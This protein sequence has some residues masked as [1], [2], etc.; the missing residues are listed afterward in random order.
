MRARRGE[1][2]ESHSSQLFNQG[3]QKL[4]V[5]N[6]SNKR[7]PDNVRIHCTSIVVLLAAMR[8]ARGLIARPKSFCRTLAWYSVSEFGNI[9]ILLLV[10]CY[11][12]ISSKHG[13]FVCLINISGKLKLQT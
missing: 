3:S 1:K 4:D 13:L 11:K 2:G 6:R 12:S 5:K 10:G 9:S 7:H 8:N